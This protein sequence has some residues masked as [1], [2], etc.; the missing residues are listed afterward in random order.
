MAL[1]HMKDISKKI[2]SISGGMAVSS[3]LPEETHR[4]TIDLDFNMYWGGKAKDFWHISK[5]LFEFLEN[6]GYEVKGQRKNT[7]YD[8]TYSKG[9]NSFMLQHQRRSKPSFRKNMYC[10]RRE[11][12]NRRTVSKN[13]MQYEVISP[14]DIIVRKLARMFKFKEQHN[15]P[16][17]ELRTLPHLKDHIEEEKQAL[18]QS[19]S[20][21]HEEIIHLRM[22]HDFYDIKRLGNYIGVNTSYLK[23]AIDDW[24]T[25]PEKYLACLEEMI[26][27]S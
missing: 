9:E 18:V 19:P 12:E 3:Y 16:F 27:S 15:L 1:N 21:T 14:E 6:K 22:E 7:T 17:P 8:I 5:P 26:S 2:A 23:R 13:G 24:T 10:F 25:E 11:F 20:K 4:H